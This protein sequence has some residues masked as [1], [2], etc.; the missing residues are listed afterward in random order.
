MRTLRENR[1]QRRGIS[2]LW[3]SSALAGLAAPSEVFSM[4]QFA[5]LAGHWPDD[6]PSNAGNALVVGGLEGCLDL[7]S[8]PDAEQWLESDLR[9]V[10][11]QFQGYYNSD[12]A[13]VFWLPTGRGRVRMNRASETYF[14]VCGAPYTGQRL[15]LGRILW[16]GAEADAARIID[17]TSTNVDPDGPAWIG[18][19]H[20]RLS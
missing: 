11:V 2:L 5:A 6:L 7:L 3:D 13:L 1:W 12:A 17:P 16:A 18:L 14:W 10:I 20:P 9:R 8:P 19:Y 15:D 4:R